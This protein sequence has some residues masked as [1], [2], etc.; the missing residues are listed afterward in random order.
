MKRSKSCASSSRWGFGSV[1]RWAV[2]AAQSNRI[3]AVSGSA[4]ALRF[5]GVGGANGADFVPETARCER[6]VREDQA[7]D[8]AGEGEEEGEGGSAC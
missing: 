3:A 5:G 6:A 1:N 4:F 7:G 8:E 2:V